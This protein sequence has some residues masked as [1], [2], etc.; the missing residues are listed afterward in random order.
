MH[1]LVPV[2]AASMLVSIAPIP[3]QPPAPKPRTPVEGVWRNV[4]QTINDRALAGDKLGVGYHIY[5]AGYFAA[6][7]ESDVPPR[8]NLTAEQ[9]EN[10]TAKEIMAVY[11]PFVAQL[12]TYEIA[13]DVMTERVLVAKN[14][15]SMTGQE[16][17]RRFRIEGNTLITEP[18]KRTPGARSIVLKFVRVE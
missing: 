2:V 12:G 3:Q 14:P 8:P 7:R 13:G 5:T 1:R 9:M 17:T 4:E 16:H 15:S 11:G 6:V 18:V 10:A